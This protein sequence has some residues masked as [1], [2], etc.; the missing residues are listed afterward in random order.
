MASLYRKHRPR[1]FADVVGQEHIVRTLQAAVEQDRV[2]HAYLFAGPRG[3]GKTSLAKILAKALNCVNG[4]TP[5]PDGT[6]E[7]CMAIHEAR[8]LDVIE[9][10]AASNRGIDTIRETVIARAALAPIEGG[11]KIYI[12]DEAHS[13]TADASNALLKTLEE[14]PEKVVFILCT[15]DANKLLPTVRSRCQRFAFRRP[16]P[17]E[18]ATVLRRIADAEQI[19][20]A[21]AALHLM[22]R[23]AGGSFRDAVGT[24]DQLATVTHGQISADEAARVLGLVPEQAL[25]DIVDLIADGDAGG[26]LRRI[27]ELAGGG[28]D[29]S[30]LV[31]ALLDRL[32]LLY[33]LQHAG[34]LPASAEPPPDRLE[35][36]RRQSRA[37]P[38]GETV[39]A[40]DLLVVAQSELREGSDPRL[41]LELAL[42]KSTRPAAGGRD[43]LLAR[44]ER[45][46][47]ALAGGAPT[48]LPATAPAPVAET[49]SAPTAEAPPPPVSEP[50]EPAEPR[51][52][53]TISVPEA[54]AGP[55]PAPVT[56]PLAEPADLDVLREAWPGVLKRLDPATRVALDPSQPAIL[57]EGALMVHVRGSMLAVASRYGEALGRA[58]AEECGVRVNPSF[59]AADEPARPRQTNGAAE[60]DA[61]LEAE[62]PVGSEALAARLLSEFDAHEEQD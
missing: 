62:P 49:G 32:R 2:A 48:P 18:L 51:E 61:E 21:D 50:T 4:P 58:V 37:L 45:L 60:A 16:G 57:N 10:D 30:T 29:L 26:V 1:T 24:L 34:E 47:S 54:A 56:A 39:R 14:P 8:S 36:L 3:T 11:R 33:L 42:L 40:I 22:A 17:G 13:L 28:Q 44:V 43:L 5:T 55:P 7:R 27:D 9:L 38:P 59:S 25:S 31:P 41:S 20:A 23:A 12:L 52:P 53:V 6:C 46:E 15:T 19:E 35:D